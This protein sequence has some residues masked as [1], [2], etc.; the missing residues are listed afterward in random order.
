MH[1]AGWFG[2]GTDRTTSFPIRVPLGEVKLQSFYAMKYVD[3]V[4]V[5]LDLRFGIVG[6]T[7]FV[8]FFG[9]CAYYFLRLGTAPSIATGWFC[10]AMGGAIVATLAALFTVWMPHD[11]GFVLLW[12]SG[13]GTGLWVGR[14]H[15]GASIPEVATRKR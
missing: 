8:L 13:I 4:Y 11:I 14:N 3:N 5:L 9:T 10:A 15:D 2:F 6:V 1:R 12:S 7:C